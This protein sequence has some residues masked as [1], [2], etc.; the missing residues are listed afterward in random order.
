[1]KKLLGLLGAAGLVATTS[2]TVVACGGDKEE[3]KID[4]S[5]LTLTVESGKTL[6]EAKT[7]ITKQINEK[8]A[9]AKIDTDFTVTLKSKE[10]NDEETGKDVLKD[11]TVLTVAATGDSKLLTGS[12]EVEVGAKPESEKKD[13]SK[14]TAEIKAETTQEDAKKAIVAE[15]EKLSKDAKETVDYTIAFTKKTNEGEDVVAEG[16]S[17]KVEATKS[18]KLLTGTATIV[19]VKK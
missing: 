2:A 4:L 1:M 19:V 11:G 7:D 3:E 14:L 9:D 15:I 13:I 5:K 18:S 16:D 10:A 17:F 6:E 12:K 8:S